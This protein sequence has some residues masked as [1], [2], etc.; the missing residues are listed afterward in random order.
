MNINGYNPYK[1]GFDML[2]AD[3]EEHEARCVTPS[4][5]EPF[6]TK[7][8]AEGVNR[9][10][11]T[12]AE[13]RM[14]VARLRVIEAAAVAC[15]EHPVWNDDHFYDLMIDLQKALR[16]EVGADKTANDRVEGRDAALSRRV[17]SHDG[18]EGK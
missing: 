13:L 18:L 1:K 10:G 3:I 9:I 6:S 4:R 5:C 16:G 2:V 11:D 12:I 15:S 7:L 14:E 17:P 8:S